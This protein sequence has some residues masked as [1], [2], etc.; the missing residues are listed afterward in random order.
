[1]IFLHILLIGDFYHVSESRR[2]DQKARKIGEI[3]TML[4]IL[5]ENFRR[6]CKFKE[7]VNAK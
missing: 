7:C 6:I 2:F 5:T 1:M 4:E 3:A